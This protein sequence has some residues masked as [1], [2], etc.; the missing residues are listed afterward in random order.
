MNDGLAN[1]PESEAEPFLDGLS[2]SNAPAFWSAVLVEVLVRCG[3][4]H[5][6]IA[7]GSR[8]GPLAVA[9]AR[10]PRVDAISIIDER[11]AGFFALGLAKREHLAAALVCTSGTAAS[12]FY[13]AIIEARESNTALLVLTADRPPELRHCQAG[14]TIDQQKIYGSYVQFYA[15]L[16]LPAVAEDLLRYLRQTIILAWQRTLSPYPGPVHLNVPFRD[17]LSP[18]SNTAG[19]VLEQLPTWNAR[20]FF[21]R[22][23]LIPNTSCYDQDADLSSLLAQ[24]RECRKGLLI[25]GSHQPRDSESFCNAVGEVSQHLGWPVLA[26]VLNPLRNWADRVPH[27]ITTYDAI[28]RAK[29]RAGALEPSLVVRIGPPPTSK[30][31]RSWLQAVD[32]PTW[33]LE[34]KALNLDPTHSAWKRLPTSI[35]KLAAGLDTPQT[36]ASKYLRDWLES[37]QLALHRID[38]FMR[39]QAAGFEGKVVYLLSRSLP[40]GT[41]VFLANSLPV[42]DAEYFWKPGNN[43]VEV[44]FN[45]GANGIDGT[46]STAAGLAHVGGPVVLVTGDLAFLHDVNGLLLGD[47]IRGHLTV[48]LI[49]NHGGGIFEHLP[50]AAIDPPYE[51]FFATPQKINVEAIAAGYAA[52]YIRL[53][54]IDAL[55][56]LVAKLPRRGM[57]IVEIEINRKLSSAARRALFETFENE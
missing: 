55:P 56:G 28:L 27:L 2:S 9:F 10:H 6:V 37:N 34:P 14:Q 38:T 26:D 18:D 49:N 53:E 12:N 35:V 3:L 16:A 33:I 46:V 43:R 8:S 29:G 51:E 40:S 24:L 21:S 47:R 52:D 44:G 1:P 15:E 25:V 11:S 57:R 17:P 4:R 48:V 42:R 39:G 41:H 45:R 50:V 23:S 30:V 32:R 20:S 13:P 19:S 22:I 5:A 7:P 31:L 36:P 54:E